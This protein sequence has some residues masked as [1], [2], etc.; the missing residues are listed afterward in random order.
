MTV[1]GLNRVRPIVNRY[2]NYL[3][4]YLNN[5][6]KR[7]KVVC[8]YWLALRNNKNKNTCIDYGLVKQDLFLPT[9]MLNIGM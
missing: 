9:M 5:L 3:N 2:E 7:L 6:P 4:D 8:S 1:T